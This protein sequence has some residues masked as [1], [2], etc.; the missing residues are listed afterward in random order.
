M[1]KQIWCHFVKK[2]KK[3]KVSNLF[4]VF[5]SK[6]F[7]MVLITTYNH[8]LSLTFGVLKL[9]IKQCSESLLMAKLS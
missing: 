3:S 7:I 4:T 2:K 6:S 8:L 9:A 5:K 1:A